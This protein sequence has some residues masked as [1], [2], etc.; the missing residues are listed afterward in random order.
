M[1]Q[2]GNGDT[3]W[4]SM[5]SPALDEWIIEI[6]IYWFYHSS[7]GSANS[8]PETSTGYRTKEQQAS[9]DHWPTRPKDLLLT[10]RVS[11]KT[12]ND[13]WGEKMTFCCLFFGNEE[14]FHEPW[15]NITCDENI[16]EIDL[17]CPETPKWKEW[18]GMPKNKMKRAVNSDPICGIGKVGIPPNSAIIKEEG[19]TERHRLPGILFHVNHCNSKSTY[20]SW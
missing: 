11:W 15:Q 7:L 10:T 6:Y 2:C 9:Q 13:D 14:T 20:Y 8:C 3:W 17:R 16:F 5:I 12:I 19:L 1:W 18:I 4:Y